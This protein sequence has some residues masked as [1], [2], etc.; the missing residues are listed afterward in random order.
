MTGIIQDLRYA[1]RQLRKNP[2]FTAV[3]LITIALGI[4]ANTAIFS[5]INGVLIR[6]LPYH[7]A[8][9]LALIWSIGRDGDKRDQ[10]SFTDIDDY[11]SQNHVFENV[12]AFGDWSATLIGAGDPARIPGMQV[13]DGYF[14]LMRAKPFLGRDFF[15]RRTD[16]G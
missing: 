1:L 9:S 12:V 6:D 10:L 11:R 5:V 16:R 3:V 15:A 2:G 13:G 8:S 7:D 14:S 4:G